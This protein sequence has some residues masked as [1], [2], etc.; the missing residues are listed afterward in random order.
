M[1]PAKSQQG[2]LL[3]LVLSLLIFISVI[4][5]YLLMV[6]TLK[7]RNNSLYIAKQQA[8]FAALSGLAL[9]QWQWAQQIYP[10]EQWHFGVS[11]EGLNHYQVQLSWQS[12]I[13][14]A[15]ATRGSWGSDFFVSS[16]LQQ[17]IPADT[18]PL[19]DKP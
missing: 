8:Y 18:G 7:Q 9:A 3:L 17:N 14:S 1:S 12:Q 11:D 10:S 19:H 15:Q 6:T 2:F 4:L 13:F 16:T 5:S